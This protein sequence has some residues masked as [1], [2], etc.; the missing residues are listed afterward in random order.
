M[1]P[2]RPRPEGKK[3]KKNSLTPGR[4]PHQGVKKKK[5]AKKCFFLVAPT[6]GKSIR[7]KGDRKGQRERKKTEGGGVYKG[8]VRRVVKEKVIRK[9]ALESKWKKT[10]S[11]T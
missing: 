9:S 5:G 3:R 11:I 1:V 8:S 6:G 4:F 10:P 7:D 2:A